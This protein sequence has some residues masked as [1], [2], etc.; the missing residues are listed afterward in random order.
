M[1]LLSHLNLTVGEKI[2]GKY[3]KIPIVQ[4]VGLD[5]F[6]PSEDWMFFMINKLINLKKGL[7]VDVGVNLGQTLLCVKAINK[8]IKYI[9]FEPNPNC[10][11]YTNELIRHNSFGYVK[12]IPAGIFSFDGIGKLF[13]CKDKNVDS[14]ATLLQ[15]FRDIAGQENI[16]VPVVSSR[17]LGLLL[18]ED[19][20]I[21]KIDVEGAELEVIEQLMEC[22]EKFRPF[23]ICEIL[24]AYTND[25][26]Y[27]IE[28]QKR[29]EYLFLNL[30]YKVLQIGS[31]IKSIEKI[32]VLDDIKM[33]N[34]L[35]FPKEMD[36]EPNSFS[37]PE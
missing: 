19:V 2:N 22:I 29:I 18:D 4:G 14:C 6:S 1:G 20:S 12:L 5:H 10:I 23:I 35:F 30:N 32:P 9:G 13:F 36:I 16:M 26:T 34:Y 33:S 37:I 7:F 31:T 15:D 8:D 21:I 27:R 28:R 24:P 11:H 25:N 3:F 17:S